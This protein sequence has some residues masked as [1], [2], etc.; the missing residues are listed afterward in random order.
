[1]GA[2]KLKFK[3][4]IVVV[5]IG[6]PSKIL[7]QRWV[8]QNICSIVGDADRSSDCSGRR[9]E[10]ATSGIIHCTSNSCHHTT[11]VTMIWMR[12]MKVGWV[13]REEKTST[14]GA[15][16][17]P[18]TKIRHTVM[19]VMIR[20]VNKIPSEMEV[21]PRYNCW[22]LLNTVE[23]FWTMLNTVEHC[24]TMWK[25]VLQCWILLSIVEH[26]WK[27]WNTVIHCWIQC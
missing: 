26:W 16:H 7:D 15:P 23:Q 1:M 8:G 12:M 9:T 22:T 17:S 10:T 20:V 21:A 19:M 24:R 3:I 11:M 4:G 27:M 18:T 13:L 14:C 5:T 6:S 25:T 2:H